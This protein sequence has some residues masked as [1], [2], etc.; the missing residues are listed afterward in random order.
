MK[1]SF[2]QSIALAGLLGCCSGAHAHPPLAKASVNPSILPIRTVVV[3]KEVSGQP[4]NYPLGIGD[5]ASVTGKPV[6]LDAFRK[7]P[8]LLYMGA[9]DENDAVAFDDAYS[10]ED[11]EIVYRLMGK[12]LV[13]QRWTFMQEVYRQNQ[14]GA[15]F[16]TYPNIGHGTDLKINNDLV[17]FFRSHMD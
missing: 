5:V 4:L 12:Q 1:L 10:E 2:L 6:D 17:A 9:R 3:V 8:Q 15:E 11:R 14:V 7:L 13:P 16:R